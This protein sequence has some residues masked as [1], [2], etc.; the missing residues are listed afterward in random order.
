MNSEI[1]I[2]YLSV[3]GLLIAAAYV[4]Y[5]LLLAGSKMPGLNRSVIMAVYAASL[6]APL[7]IVFSNATVADGANYDEPTETVVTTNLADAESSTGNK[8]AHDT[9]LPEETAESHHPFSLPTAGSYTHLK[10]PPPSRV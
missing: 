7:A 2:A 5:R 3:S 6:L 1:I 9:I 8:Y 4:V 10:L